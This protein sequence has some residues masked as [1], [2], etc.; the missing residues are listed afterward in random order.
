MNVKLQADRGVQ[1]KSKTKKVLGILFKVLCA[2]IIA[3]LLL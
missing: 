1:S 3:I 2:I